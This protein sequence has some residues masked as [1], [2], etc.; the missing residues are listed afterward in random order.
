VVGSVRDA[1]GVM[2]SPLGE[3]LPFGSW[4]GQPRPWGADGRSRVWFGGQVV[5]GLAQMIDEHVAAEAREREP[6][7]AVLGCV[8]WLTHAGIAER[9]ARLPACCV[10]VDKGQQRLAS[11]LATAGNGFPP[12]LPGLRHRAPAVDGRA[13]VLGPYSRMPD[14]AVGPVRVVGMTGGER[15]KPL[16]HA[17]LLVLGRLVW[18]E[19]EVDGGCGEVYL[20]QPRSVW[21]GSANWTEQARHHLELGAWSDDPALAREATAFL[22]DLIGFSE[23]LGSVSPRP[24]PDLAYVDY[25]DEAM[26]EAMA[27]A[28]PWF[29]DE[30]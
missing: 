10:V 8:P 4:S 30:P 27:A 7:P 23:P 3:Y 19:Y 17:K 6:M 1:V 22:D 9:L 13:V 24:D 5:D 15:S 14:Y 16:L 11:A 25:D 18:L 12:V 21:W 2:W 26:R 28:E 29:G 20:F